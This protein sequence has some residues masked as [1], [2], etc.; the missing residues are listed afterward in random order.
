MILMW[1]DDTMNTVFGMDYSNIMQIPLYQSYKN[2]DDI[3]ITINEGEFKDTQINFIKGDFDEEN[4][5]YKPLFIN[6]FAKHNQEVLLS[7]A[8][9]ILLKELSQT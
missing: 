9:N 1:M 6:N 2:G 5:E 7:I 4:L 8:G 3:L